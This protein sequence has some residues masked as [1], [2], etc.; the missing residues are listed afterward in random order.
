MLWT[1]LLKKMIKFKPSI[2]KFI[3]NSTQ[4]RVFGSIIGQNLMMKN[5]RRKLK[6]FK[7]KIAVIK[8]SLWWQL[9]ARIY[10]NKSKRFTKKFV[11]NWWRS[12]K[13]MRSIAKKI[14]KNKKKKFRKLI[15]RSSHPWKLYKMMIMNTQA[16]F[17]ECYL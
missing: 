14:R 3:Y 5:L 9:D 4:L 16:Y 2:P 12:F 15:S 17:C 10:K 8:N 13:L 11:K 1:R 6:N 7:L